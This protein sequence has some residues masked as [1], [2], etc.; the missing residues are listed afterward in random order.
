[1]G[2]S[3]MSLMFTPYCEDFCEYT[4]LDQPKAIKTAAKGGLL[5]IAGSGTVFISHEVQHAVTGRK[6]NVTS[7]LFLVYHVPGMSQRLLSLGKLLQ[8]G[9]LML[10]DKTHISLYADSGRDL[11]VMMLHPHSP[12]QTIY[13]LNC[14]IVPGESLMVK[15]VVSPIDYDVLH[16]HFGHA[17]KDALKH[18]SASTKNLPIKEVV[19]PKKDTLVCKGCTESKMPSRTFSESET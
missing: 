7:W 12:R 11:P 13:W 18:L 2:D 9:Y 5:K 16:K 6:Y 14:H 19:F 15:S 1:M 17:S 10:G 8:Q 3:G 4:T